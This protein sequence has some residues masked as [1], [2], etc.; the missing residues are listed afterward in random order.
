V[1]AHAINDIQ[2]AHAKQLKDLANGAEMAVHAA[3][4]N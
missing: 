3:A 4:D 1:G 2:P